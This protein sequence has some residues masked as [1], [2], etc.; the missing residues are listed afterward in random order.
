VDLPA[1]IER[2]LEEAMRRIEHFQE[3]HQIQS[4]VP[5]N[6]PQVY[7]ALRHIRD[8]NLA[9]GNA[10][11]EWGSG[12]GVISCLAQALGFS[13]T[14][15]EVQ[16]ELVD[17]AQQLA[18]DFQFDVDFYRDSFVP[19]DS[20]V[21]FANEEASAW[22]TEEAGSLED[23][24]IAPENFDI[25][26]VYPWPGEEGRTEKLF[27]FHASQGALLLSYHG[28]D[29]MKLQRKVRDKARRR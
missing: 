16:A 8:H 4:F 21:C 14:G 25:I 23:D 24:G 17:H 28:R 19:Q 6:F 5:S 18:R 1:N 3:H 9:A 12:F 22:L 2:F 29:D 13:A 27:D 10:F 20:D 11:C 7:V 15:I 26:F